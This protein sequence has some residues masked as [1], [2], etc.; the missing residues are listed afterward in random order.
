MLRASRT[1]AGR[2]RPWSARRWSSPSRSRTPRCGSSSGPPAPAH[3]PLPRRGVPVPRRSSSSRASLVLIG[4][5]PVRRALVRGLRSHRRL[6]SRHG[7]RGRAFLPLVPHPRA[8]H[9]RCPTRTRRASA[10]RL[11]DVAL[12]GLLVLILWAL[13]PRLRGAQRPGP[14]RS[15]R[16]HRTDR[17][18]AQR[19]P[20]DR[21]LRRG[22]GD[23]RRHRRPH[24]RHSALPAGRV[25]ARRRR[26]R[27]GPTS[28]ASCRAARRPRLRLHG[29]RGRR[30]DERTAEIALDPAG[31]ARLRAGPVRVVAVRRLRGGSAT[32]SR[33]P[34]A[35]G[36]P[37]ELT[38]KASGD[39][40]GRLVEALRAGVPAKVSGRSAASTTG[41]AARADLDRRRHRRDAVHELAPLARRRLRPRR[42]LLL[43]G[44]T[45]GRCRLSRRDPGGRA[46]HPSLRAH[47]VLSERRAADRRDGAARAPRHDATRRSTCAARHR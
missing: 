18:L 21:P 11:G 7:R 4:L 41:P 20:A 47:V 5:V 9:R 33:S 22:G 3:G 35:G 34:G 24:L 1:R 42:R 15:T 27:R 43:L 39:Y 31:G 17:A 46:A 8:R 16:P 14:V 45:P 25:R 13:A 2:R 37:L 32:R 29:R 44:P 28:T 19:A 38:I 26:R 6:A 12:L 23:A 10:T 36:P 30:L 40:T